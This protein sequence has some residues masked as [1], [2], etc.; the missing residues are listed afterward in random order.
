MLNLYTID[1][2][3]AFPE[4][5]EKVVFYPI[6]TP[7]PCNIYP[8]I[9]DLSFYPRF[10]VLFKIYPFI[11]RFILLSARFILLFG[12]DKLCVLFSYAFA[13]QNH[14]MINNAQKARNCGLFEVWKLYQTIREEWKCRME[15]I[16]GFQTI[17]RQKMALIGSVILK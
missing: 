3:T 17:V 11:A 4:P 16:R 7:Q 12:N 1:L 9:Q 2:K 5:S 13:V 6:F 8:F 15:M 14:E 10:I